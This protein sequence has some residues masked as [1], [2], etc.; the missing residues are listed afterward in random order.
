MPTTDA[1]GL[2]SLM[3]ELLR[4]GIHVPTR[5][6]WMRELLGRWGTLPIVRYG[7]AVT[8]GF[9]LALHG[10]VATLFVLRGAP[11]PPP[12]AEPPPAIDPAPAMAGE[13]FMLP[14]PETT[15]T[16]LAN[17]APSP[18]TNAAPAPPEGD[19]PARPTPPSNA[20]SAA[21]PSH[22]G[23]PSAG[24]APSGADESTSASSGSTALYGA[25]GD[26]SAADLSGSFVRALSHTAS[27][28]AAWRSVPFGSAGEA[29]LTVTLDDAGHLVDSQITG[30]HSAALANAIR[31][32]MTL[33][34]AR[35]FVAKGKTT[36]LKITANV[37][38]HTVPDG[39]H[40]DVFAVGGSFA[41]SEGSAFFALAIGRRVDFHI[42]AQH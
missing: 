8:L 12:S 38:P 40:G 36:K 42:R 31:G 5:T 21:R 7:L 27:A 24:H 2:P 26:R 25:V 15:E 18:D 35:P 19:A 10:A 22:R 37:T 11:V 41:Q 13:T 14:A 17:A 1:Q 20:K 6:R 4:R 33:I 3:A 32:T 29:T 28:D 39:L 34:K 16:P 9:S 23:R 30:S